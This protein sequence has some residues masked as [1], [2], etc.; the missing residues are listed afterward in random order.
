M[1]QSLWLPKEV[2]S[3]LKSENLWNVVRAFLHCSETQKLS[4]NCEYFLF[5]I[6]EF[7]FLLYLN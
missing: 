4:E 7:S 6:W 5:I 2:S 3:E 1:Y